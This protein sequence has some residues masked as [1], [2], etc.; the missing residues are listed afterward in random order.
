MEAKDQL[1]AMQVGV[2]KAFFKAKGIINVFNASTDAYFVTPIQIFVLTVEIINI[3]RTIF[4]IY[5]QAIAYNVQML[6]RAVCA[7]WTLY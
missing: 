2:L 7:V 1:N 5:V 4:A 6:V 3:L